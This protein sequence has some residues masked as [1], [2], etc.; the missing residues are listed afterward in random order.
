M[1]V[2]DYPPSVPSDALT[3]ALFVLDTSVLALRRSGLILD[4][5]VLIRHTKAGAVGRHELA[6][7]V[8]ARLTHRFDPFA[9]IL[10]VA[11]GA[12]AALC[13]TFIEAPVWSWSVFAVFA[14]IALI[15]LVS[16]LPAKLTIETP[17]GAVH[18]PLV[19]ATDEVTGFYLSLQERM[20]RLG[21]GGSPA[22]S[23][24]G[25]RFE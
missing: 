21:A 18:Y 15:G 8:S 17:H 10:A 1:V 13:K 24:S 14:A 7:V 19:E 2:P 23:G 9:A 25:R 20:S 6:S 3:E 4:N 22:A 12:I 16:V 11:A 5:D